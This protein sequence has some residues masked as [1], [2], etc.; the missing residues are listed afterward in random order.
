MKTFYWFGLH[1]LLGLWLIVSPYVLGFTSA[2][3]SYWNSIVLG[4]L[5][6]LSSAIAMYYGRDQLAAS[7]LS[8]KTQKA[9]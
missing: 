6:I 9:A 4:A 7:Q 3:E 1:L 5:F 8:H 2:V